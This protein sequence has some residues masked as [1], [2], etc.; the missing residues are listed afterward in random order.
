MLYN[1]NKHNKKEDISQYPPRYKQNYYDFVKNILI[2]I[3]KKDASQHL[4][5]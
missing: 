1:N 2:K 3:Q 4:K 5:I